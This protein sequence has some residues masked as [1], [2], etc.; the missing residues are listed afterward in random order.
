[1]RRRVALIAAAA[2]ALTLAAGAA[3]DPAGRSSQSSGLGSPFA[4]GS[5]TCDPSVGF[6][7]FRATA[8]GDYSAPIAELTTNG[9]ATLEAYPK[10]VDTGGVGVVWGALGYPVSAGN[11]VTVEIF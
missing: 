7:T 6:A 4:S 3:G 1:M 2:V 10:N 8:P 9:P 5:G 11:L